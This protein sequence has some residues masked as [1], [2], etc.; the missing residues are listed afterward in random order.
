M[1]LCMLLLSLFRS[2]QSLFLDPNESYFAP[3]LNTLVAL[4]TTDSIAL[5]TGAGNKYNT[6][7]PKGKLNSMQVAPSPFSFSLETPDPAAASDVRRDEGGAALSGR[8]QD[9]HELRR[10]HLFHRRV[11]QRQPRQ[12]RF[13]RLAR[14]VPERSHEAKGGSRAREA[15]PGRLRGA[16]SRSARRRRFG[17]VFALRRTVRSHQNVGSGGRF[18]VCGGVGR[19]GGWRQRQGAA[20]LPGPQ[21]ERAGARGGPAVLRGFAGNRGGGDREGD[22]FERKRR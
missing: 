18:A 20:V 22:A 9:L 7:R 6:N 3:L 15:V 17:A 4:V 12:R 13:P 16:A 1:S 8:L 5:E 19:D 21:S 10:L 2:F 14:R 11:P